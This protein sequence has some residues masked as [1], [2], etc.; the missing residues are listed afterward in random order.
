M[1]DWSKVNLDRFNEGRGTYARNGLKYLSYPFHMRGNQDRKALDAGTEFKLTLVVPRRR[2]PGDK[3]MHDD[4]VRRGWLASLWLLGGV[5]SLGTRSRRGFGSLEITNWA[6]MTEPSEWSEGASDL[7][8]LCKAR[9]AE[10]WRTAFS[11]GQEIIGEWF[12]SFQSYQHYHFGH[13]HF[14]PEVGWRLLS[15]YG[16]WAAALDVA[17][18]RLQDFRVR[19]QPDYD[20]VKEALRSGRPLRQTPERAAFGLPL[21][22]RYTS[23]KEA[24]T[25]QFVPWDGKKSRDRHASLLRIRLVRIGDRFHPLFLR[26]S[27]A[28]PGQ[29]P[30]ATLVRA[31]RHENLEPTSG[32]LLDQFMFQLAGE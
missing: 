20:R 18:R 2:A 14:G 16:D 5:G 11:R 32:A 23:L 24:R 15:G 4:L 17:G 30:E 25:A 13:P 1:F 7:P 28:V 21:T 27:G 19:R 31:R 26:L 9:D 12:E 10:D 8:D 22:F 3:Q 6:T 29:N